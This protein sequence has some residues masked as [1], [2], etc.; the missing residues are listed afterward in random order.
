MNAKMVHQNSLERYSGYIGADLGTIRLQPSGPLV[1]TVP[2]S[3]S[4]K[5]RNQH[6]CGFLNTLN[7][8]MPIQFIQIVL[9]KLFYVVH[10]P[11]N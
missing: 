1:R 9:T 7:S 10:T 4:K 8:D 6:N 2:R 11:L 3:A 5:N